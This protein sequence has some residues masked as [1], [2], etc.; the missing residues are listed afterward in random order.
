MQKGIK[1][2]VVIL[3][4][5]KIQIHTMHNY[6]RRLIISAAFLLP[7]PGLLC[8]RLAINNINELPQLSCPFGTDLRIFHIHCF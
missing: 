7:L 3:P 2:V 5:S 1:L 8:E 6:I 4:S